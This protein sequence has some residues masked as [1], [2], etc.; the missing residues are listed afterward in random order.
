MK[1][2]NKILFLLLFETDSFFFFL[3]SVQTKKN[4]C[5]RRREI[6]DTVIDRERRRVGFFSFE[7]SQGVLEDTWGYL[8]LVN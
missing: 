5:L 6:T 8:C 1:K 3:F 7:E 4:L 2:Y